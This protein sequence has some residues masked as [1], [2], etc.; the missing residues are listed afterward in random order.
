[1][2]ISAVD[3]VSPGSVEEPPTDSLSGDPGTLARQP[4][5][6]LT[7]TG[8]AYNRSADT[9]SPD[10]ASADNISADDGSPDN[11]STDNGSPDIRS[12][13]DRS[14]DTGSPDDGS[15]DNGSA[16]NGSADNRSAD[17]GSA[18]NGS[19]DNRSADTGSP[20]DGS[21]DTGSSD[22]RSADNRSAD[23]GSPDNGSPVNGSADIRSAD[24]R[25]ADTGSPD[26]RP[27]D[28]RLPDNGS[29]D[30]RP[31]DNG[32][33]DN[34][35]AD[36]VP[37]N[38]LS[39]DTVP[40]MDEPP[41][42]K[43][44]SD[45]SPILF[46]ALDET[47]DDTV[48]DTETV[49]S[50]RPTFGAF[51]ASLATQKQKNGHYCH[52]LHQVEEGVCNHLR[53]GDELRYIN[54][55]DVSSWNHH[56]VLES[57]RHLRERVTFTFYR[58][59]EVFEKGN[60]M[61]TED[62]FV[63]ITFIIA[64]QDSDGKAPTLDKVFAHIIDVTYKFSKMIRY[65]SSLT[66]MTYL[67]KTCVKVAHGVQIHHFL[68]ALG[69]RAVME[70]Q[71]GQL[72]CYK[73]WMYSYAVKDSKDDN[74]KSVVA[75]Q[76]VRCQ[77]FLMCNMRSKKLS[78]VKKNIDS[79]LTI[80]KSNSPCLFLMSSNGSNASFLESVAYDGLFLGYDA[81]DELELNRLHRGDMSSVRVRANFSFHITPTTP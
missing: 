65:N 19:A 39:A 59:C 4:T 72:E 9:G 20:D 69:N 38:D 13:D 60:M 53:S 52:R 34:R 11:G 3:E 67:G 27:A 68:R 26:N 23:T 1:M 45:W 81:V 33:A 6:C 41:V 10:N 14:A 22:I 24:N 79:S 40:S 50:A 57:I 56:E 32:P 78:L 21:P 66:V 8:S 71:R 2:F 17:T 35:S 31:P 43:S 7:D 62:T 36:D 18:D 75:F 73:F 63:E 61:R 47:D 54:K 16:D 48:T 58:K 30:N 29:P 5:A 64:D 44:V 76:S 77:L 55:T 28:N 49:D 15:P 51:G 12:A 37:P 25:S 46:R 70:Q 42:D 74:G 80:M